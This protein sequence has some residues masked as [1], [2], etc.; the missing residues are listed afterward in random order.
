[1]DGKFD[2]PLMRLLFGSPD[3]QLR[4]LKL[5]RGDARDVGEQ[6]LR[7]EVHSALLQ[8]QMGDAEL[9]TTFQDIPKEHGV[10]IDKLRQLV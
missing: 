7:D 4:N 6:E 3:K 8:V 2:D 9:C 10:T 5:L 1:M